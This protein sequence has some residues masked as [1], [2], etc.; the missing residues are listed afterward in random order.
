[1]ASTSE[2][3]KECE[4]EESDKQCR[5]YR[6]DPVGRIDRE[7]KALTGTPLHDE[8]PLDSFHINQV[9]SMHYLGVEGTK[10]MI[11]LFPAEVGSILDL[12][13][14]FGGCSRFVANTLGANSHVTALELQK[15]I[16]DAA[17]ILTKRCSLTS[18]V[19]H[20]VGDILDDN[21]LAKLPRLG[22]YDV[23]FSKLVVLHIP[24]KTR[25][26]LWSSLAQAA[27][28]GLL[29][30]EDYFES[31]ELSEEERASL[32]EEVGCPEI[33]SRESY[34]EQLSQVCLMINFTFTHTQLIY[35]ILF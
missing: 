28:G 19:S 27:P 15:N 5:L 30:L 10:S 6:L 14:G 11:K 35:H 12:G 9:D 8:T 3:P 32:A 22:A 7:L 16:S 2:T 20:V 18:S 33:P 26:K 4:V 31:R 1:M 21:V 24:F 23:V 13:S 34:I 17:E 29:Y 25:T